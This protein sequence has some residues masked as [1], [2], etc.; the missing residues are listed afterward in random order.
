MT[1]KEKL[2]KL[3]E[4]VLNKMQEMLDNDRTDE[5]PSLSTVVNYLR[6][7]QE[8]SEKEKRT[9][10]DRHAEMVKEAKKKRADGL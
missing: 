7:N 6:A 1:K 3:D 8:V 5:L 4:T 9:A 10:S 2:K